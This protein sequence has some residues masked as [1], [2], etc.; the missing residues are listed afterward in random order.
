M[1]RPPEVVMTGI[2]EEIAETA[3][4]TAK[5]ADTDKEKVRIEI[6]TGVNGTKTRGEKRGETA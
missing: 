1:S 6:T 3:A 5:M 4:I 2:E